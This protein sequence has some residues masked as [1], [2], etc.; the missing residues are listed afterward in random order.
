MDGPDRFGASAIAAVSYQTSMFPARSSRTD[1]RSCQTYI[2][3]A[4]RGEA[5]IVE[6][7]ARRIKLEQRE[8]GRS[9]NVT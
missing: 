2:L 3:G 4:T 8:W 9:S 7:P 5:Q 1:D 6:G